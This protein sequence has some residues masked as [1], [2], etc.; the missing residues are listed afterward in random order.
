MVKI[1]IIIIMYNHFKDH[2]NP[3]IYCTNKKNRLNVSLNVHSAA[4]K[5]KNKPDGRQLR[6]DSSRHGGPREM[7]SASQRVQS[8][9]F[10]CSAL[11]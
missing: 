3:S 7:L 11:E 4:V 1:L 9:Y 2:S 10:C 6:S 5:I 8:A